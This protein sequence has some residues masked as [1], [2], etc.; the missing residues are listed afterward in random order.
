MRSF[1]VEGKDEVGEPREQDKA[2][3]RQ[4]T[5]QWGF[6]TSQIGTAWRLSPQSAIAEPYFAKQIFPE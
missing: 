1:H 2:S 5:V 3:A 4:D 6:G